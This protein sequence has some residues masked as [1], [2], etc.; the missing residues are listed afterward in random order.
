MILGTA[1][2]A[3]LI[4]KTHDGQELKLRAPRILLRVKNRFSIYD[5]VLT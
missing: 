4:P 3:R 5:V 1:D 2:L